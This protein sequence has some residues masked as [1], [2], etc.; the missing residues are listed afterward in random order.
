MTTEARA[1]QDAE[2]EAEFER[3]GYDSWI[4]VWTQ[5]GYTPTVRD[6]PARY[7]KDGPLR[8]AFIRGWNRA[9]RENDTPQ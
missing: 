2:M 1:S 6:C 7:M 4:E 5:Y 9:R 8:D 3:R